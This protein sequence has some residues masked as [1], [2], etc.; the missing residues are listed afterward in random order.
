[1]H[2]PGKK[3]DNDDWQ[4]FQ[5]AV[6]GIAPLA[7]DKVVHQTKPTP[8]SR[9]KQ[10]QQRSSLEQ[11]RVRAS[12]QFSDGYEAWFDPAQPVKFSRSKTLS[13]EVKRLRRGEYPPDLTLDLHGYNKEDAKWEIAEFIHTAKKYHH[14][15]VCIVHGIGSRVLKQQI[16]NWLVQHPDVLGFH[17]APLEWG[18]KGALL[19]LLDVQDQES[20]E[21]RSR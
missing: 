10:K 7:Q 12:F 15:C 17:Q 16:P 1:M 14:Y 13:G 18:G 21:W 6:Q 20:G 3:T 2:K 8:V 9:A 19:I 5:Q 4:L 11:R